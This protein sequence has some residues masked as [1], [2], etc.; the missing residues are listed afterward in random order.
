[1]SA[2]SA[3]FTSS[4]G[5]TGSGVPVDFHLEESDLTQGKLNVMWGKHKVDEI[6]IS[7]TEGSVKKGVD[8]RGKSLEALANHIYAMYADELAS[9][10][11]NTNGLSL[12][13]V[14]AKVRIGV[15]EVDTV[16]RDG[17]D[18]TTQMKDTAQKVYN[19]VLGTP[20]MAG[21]AGQNAKAATR[22]Q[23]HQFVPVDPENPEAM[24]HLGTS[25]VGAAAYPRMEYSGELCR[26]HQ[27]IDRLREELSKASEACNFWHSECQT[28]LRENRF[29]HNDVQGLLRQADEAQQRIREL[30]SEL[31]EALRA[32]E[33]LE[34]R[35]DDLTASNGD[36]EARLDALQEDYEELSLQCECLDHA[37]GLSQEEISYLRDSL[38]Q[39]DE[40]IR[41]LREQLDALSNSLE[42][43][44]VALAEL[45]ESGGQD[46]AAIDR[47]E[48]EIEIAKAEIGIKERA[49]ASQAS[50]YKTTI[51]KL[52]SELESAVA[53][54]QKE[55]VAHAEKTGRLTSL[56]ELCRAQA[57]QVEVFQERIAGLEQRLQDAKTRGSESSQEV[58][59]LRQ[60]LENTKAEAAQLL[61]RNGFLEGRSLALENDLGWSHY[62]EQDLM[63]HLNNAS[64]TIQM[65]A[66]SIGWLLGQLNYQQGF[67]NSLNSQLF[68]AQTTAANL[69]TQVSQM[70]ETEGVSSKVVDQARE[71]AN[72]ANEQVQGLREQLKAAQFELQDLRARVPELEARVSP[73]A[74]ALVEREAELAQKEKLLADQK[75]LIDGLRQGLE[76]KNG[77]IADLQRRFGDVVRSEQAL[78]DLLPEGIDPDKIKGTLTKL[79]EEK[80]E[81]SRQLAQANEEKT[82]LQ[83]DVSAVVSALQG[84]EED[85]PALNPDKGSISHQVLQLKADLKTA[86]SQLQEEKAVNDRLRVELLRAQLAS[87]EASTELSSMATEKELLSQTIEALRKKLTP[88]NGQAPE[89]LTEALDSLKAGWE[90]VAAGL[91]SEILQLKQ[92]FDEGAEEASQKERSLSAQLGSLQGII[93]GQKSQIEEQLGLLTD[94]ESKLQTTKE[95]N[96]NLRTEI[97]NLKEKII[98]EIRKHGT[99]ALRSESSSDEIAEAIKNVFKAKDERIQSLQDRVKVLEASVRTLGDSSSAS[100]SELATLQIEN[101]KLKVQCQTASQREEAAGERL[102]LLER[103]I[104]GNGTLETR[105]AAL[106]KELQEKGKRLESAETELESLRPQANQLAALQ[107][108]AQDLNSDLQIASPGDAK[109]FMIALKKALASE[110]KAI[111]GHQADIESLRAELTN[112][113]KLEEQARARVQEL[114]QALGEKDQQIG[115]LRDLTSNLAKVRKE[116]ESSK[117]DRA[118]ALREVN[119]IRQELAKLTGV[120]AELEETRDALIESQH[121]QRSLGSELSQIKTLL[122][123]TTQFDAQRRSDFEKNIQ[124]LEGQKKKADEQVALL[125]GQVQELET[126]VAQEQIGNAQLQKSLASIREELR[127]Q[128]F[129]STA[130]SQNFGK[131][132]SQIEASF[133]KVGIRLDEDI[134][135]LSIDEL[136]SLVDRKISGLDELAQQT[137]F[138]LESAQNERS[139][140]FAELAQALQ[141]L[142]KTQELAK[143]LTSQVGELSVNVSTLLKDKEALEARVAEQSSEILRLQDELESQ[144]AENSSLKGHVSQLEAANESLKGRVTDLTR[145]N[146]DLTRDND[147]LLQRIRELEKALTPVH[148][149]LSPSVERHRNYP[150]LTAELDAFKR[151]AQALIPDPNAVLE[152]KTVAAKEEAASKMENLVKH[153]PSTVV[154]GS[155][156]ALVNEKI[157][158]DVALYSRVLDHLI[159]YDGPEDRKELILNLMFVVASHDRSSVSQTAKA[160]LKGLWDNG[161]YSDKVK[162][163]A[164]ALSVEQGYLSTEIVSDPTSVRLGS[165]EK[166]QESALN[167]IRDI[168][169]FLD[170]GSLNQQLRDDKKAAAKQA[171]EAYLSEMGFILSDNFVDHLVNYVRANGAFPQ[172]VSS[173]LATGGDQGKRCQEVLS[174]LLYLYTACNSQYIKRFPTVASLERLK[175]LTNSKESDRQSFALLKFIQY[176]KPGVAFTHE[177]VEW[178]QRVAKAIEGAEF[179]PIYAPGGAGKTVTVKHFMRLV[180]DIKSH[181]IKLG[182]DAPPA[183]LFVSPIAQRD[184]DKSDSVIQTKRLPPPRD[185]EIQLRTNLTFEQMEKAMVAIDECHIIRPEVDVVLASTKNGAKIK[186]GQ[187]L[188]LTASPLTIG[189]DLLASTQTALEAVKT[190]RASLLGSLDA[191]AQKGDQ[192][193]EFKKARIISALRLL[194]KEESQNLEKVVEAHIRATVG[195]TGTRT[196]VQEMKDVQAVLNKKDEDID[197]DD[198]ES[199]IREFIGGSL[200]KNKGTG[201][202]GQVNCI[203]AFFK[204]NLHKP[205]KN[206]VSQEQVSLLRR[207]ELLAYDIDPSKAKEYELNTSYQT[208]ASQGGVSVKPLSDAEK[209][210]DRDLNQ[211]I[212]AGVVQNSKLT[213]SDNIRDSLAVLDQEKER[214]EALQKRY[215][216][217]PGCRIYHETKARRDNALTVMQVSHQKSL[218]RWDNNRGECIEKMGKALG[219]LETGSNDRVQIILPGIRFTEQKIDEVAKAL[220]PASGERPRVFMYHDSHSSKDTENYGQDLCCIV[221]SSGKVTKLTLEQY[222]AQHEDNLNN[223]HGSPFARSAF[224]HQV[225]M[226]YDDT[227]KQG[228]DFGL[229]SEANN[230]KSASISQLV[231]LDIREDASSPNPG[232]YLSSGDL[233]QCLCRRRGADAGDPPAPIIFACIS[234]KYAQ[235]TK[236][237]PT[238]ALSKLPSEVLFKALFN[239][240]MEKIKKLGADTASG[241]NSPTSS[242]EI[243]SARLRIAEL[244]LIRTDQKQLVER[245]VERSRSNPLPLIDPKTISLISG[246]ESKQ[247]EIE[248]FLYKTGAVSRIACGLEHL[249]TQLK[250]LPSIGERNI[251]NGASRIA[252]DRQAA[253]NALLGRVAFLKAEVD[254]TDKLTNLGSDIK[255]IKGI[256][257]GIRDK[258]LSKMKQDIQDV[259]AYENP[260]ATGRPSLPNRNIRHI[261]R[262]TD[263]EKELYAAVVEALSAL[264]EVD[265]YREQA[266]SVQS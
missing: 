241:P 98:D 129:E 90:G 17:A 54:L 68:E 151:E 1:M 253:L 177:Q 217:D 100:G 265:A 243:K 116:L 149:A 3:S 240:E 165:M 78:R 122:A 250:K 173:C 223:K 136:A 131:L 212:N 124:E 114:N 254:V 101:E 108:L 115:S 87:T 14:D 215:T 147:K 63:G 12:S 146:T 231:F 74:A 258:H 182:E 188:Q 141:E 58:A 176:S 65:Q 38:E 138:A 162:Q 118:E 209:A 18:Q 45:Q 59:S 226:L 228:G 239:Q 205:G 198:L 94:K 172:G 89:D 53:E 83:K 229:F 34:G 148:V 169:G 150:N 225:I 210:L 51:E 125:R 139:D 55:K 96:A 67:V 179:E 77:K 56:N 36:L 180:H 5:S 140:T 218:S 24:G 15:G 208:S 92:K 97:Q 158:E 152:A 23:D 8:L 224:P 84:T 22:L 25:S 167:S 95:E 117:Q 143:N 37:L 16:H 111:Q 175:W 62:R 110:R 41:L 192:Q 70:Q 252:E 186:V 256:F 91:R 52:N 260:E 144:K 80:A 255:A 112:T 13:S 50:V 221:D 61:Q 200:S 204:N 123:M 71:E 7:W 160:Y 105:L 178:G 171:I 11:K 46:K 31:Y 247:K 133:E 216:E 57:T 191:I 47:L 193:K 113:Q 119:I 27:E 163:A 107:Q 106:N 9:V 64:Q 153:I 20:V 72:A 48:E 201:L 130:H 263:A 43:K 126:K 86:L 166:A 170:I 235:K 128:I 28:A 6:Q 4:R 154:E 42:W 202:L 232:D 214:L 33:H 266:L 109:S 236:E 132:L 44:E 35:V 242:E 82:R 183:M 32:K 30:E 2:F 181:N 156:D 40:E 196:F 257:E 185:N 219:A 99:T 161:E 49:L 195:R 184:T 248:S 120:S 189:Y 187:Y 220:K 222:K 135:A 230:E 81:L 174:R 76:D 69:N 194:F 234:D 251:D 203:N 211:K 246:L 145:E 103:L 207:L 249:Q 29:I 127:S 155:L 88:E 199:K 39:Q 233:Y 190:D 262:T 159:R 168:D 157:K 197:Y 73:T 104:P 227:N 21:S 142:T 102:R 164:A 10:D 244:E 93:S 237:E 26:A 79:E 264:E 66:A 213:V 60:E 75:D 245:F 19:C 134:S 206:K 238:K 259:V 137:Q 85:K 261:E 121:R